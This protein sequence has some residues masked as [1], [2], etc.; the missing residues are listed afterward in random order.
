MNLLNVGGFYANEGCPSSRILNTAHTMES[1]V[2]LKRPQVRRGVLHIVPAEH[3]LT[4]KS[5]HRENYI[6]SPG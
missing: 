3:V 2:G 5:A 6:A 1:C 4:C